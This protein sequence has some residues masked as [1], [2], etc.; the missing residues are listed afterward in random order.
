MFALPAMMGQDVAACCTQNCCAALIAASLGVMP[1]MMLRRGGGH[2]SAGTGCLVGF[3]GVAIGGIVGAIVQAKF[4]AHD[5]TELR[6]IFS[7]SY[8]DLVRASK[9]KGQSVPFT[10]Q[11]FVNGASE[12]APYFVIL[13]VAFS[14][15]LAGGFG[16][17][18]AKFGGRRRPQ[19]PPW[20]P[21]QPPPQQPPPPQPHQQPPQV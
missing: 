17:L 16:M 1:V 5:P 20:P 21:Q 19:Q 13:V 2:P 8:D 3:F 7:Q 9:A 14:S 15:F 12:M 11:E 4:P 18:V 6:E 10:R